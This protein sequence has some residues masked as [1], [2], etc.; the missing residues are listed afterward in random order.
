MLVL[1]KRLLSAPVFKDDAEET[2]V[3]TLVNGLLLIVLGGATLFPIAGVMAGMTE[4]APVISLLS[5]SM[6]LVAMGLKLLLHRGYVRLT[7]TLL[8]SAVWISFTIPI[9]MFDG[10]R[11]VTVTGYF[12]AIA[13]V[14]LVLGG[15]TLL[16]FCGLSS[17]AIAGAYFAETGGIITTSLGTPPSLVD[18]VT[19]LIALNATA[20]LSGITVGRMKAEFE[21]AQRSAEALRQSH[22][23]LTTL[24][25]ATTVINSD[26]SRNAVLQ[27]VAREMVQA[28]GSQGCSL[29]LWDR[30]RDRVETLIDYGTWSDGTEP[31]GTAYNLHDYPATRH[32]LE[33]RQPAIIH[34]DDATADEA[35]L[36][37]MREQG[38]GT[39]LMLPW[40][41][42]DQVMGL[43]ELSD[44]AE[45][46]E[47]APEEIRLAENLAAQAAVA[48][49]NARLY[50][51][52]RRE[53]TERKR[54]EG[55]LRRRAEEL[56]ALQATVLDITARH[57]LPSLLQT[58]VERAAV[59]L[60]ASG[61]GMYLCDPVKGEVRCVVSYN[62]PTDYTGTV[63][64]YSEGAAGTVAQTGEPLIIDDYRVW[65]GRAAV[66][67]E[68]Q[69]FTAVLSVPMIWQA[70]VRGVI[71]VLRQTDGEAFTQADLELLTQFANHA[72]IAVENARLYEEAT[73]HARQQETL[74]EAALALTTT[75]DWDQV[76]ERL[77]A[78]LQQVV[79]YD[80][81][82][83]QLLR[84]ERGNSLEIVGGRGFP[85]LDKVIGLTFD[86]SQED[87]PNREVIRTRAPFIVDDAPA[88]YEE[89]HREPHASA[90]I[91]S[92]LGVPM[93]V[94]DQLIGM[95]T[96]D[97]TEPGFYDQGHARLAETFAAQAAIA[98]ENTHLYE[99]ARQEIAERRRA[100]EE[101]EQSLSLLQAT[102]ESTA[103]GILVVDKE[104][105]IASFNR[106]FVDL[107]GIPDVILDSQSDD[108][109]IAF[110]LD[111]LKNPDSF[112]AKVRELYSQPDAESFDILEFK[113]GRV[114]ERYSQAQRIGKESVG[115]VWSFRDVTERVQ[116]EEA[117]RESEERFRQI[118]ENSREVFWMRDLH[119]LEL[120]YITPAYE[121]VWGHPVEDAY[122]NPASWMES[123]HP[124]DREQVAAAFEQQM[125]GKPTENEYRIVWPDGSIRWIRDQT[126][127][128]QNEA[129]KA[130]RTVGV[131]E[132][133][134]ERRQA[135]EQILRQNVILGAV[136]RVLE[137][138]LRCET[139]EEVAHTFLSAAEALTGSRFGFVGEVNQDGRFDTVALSD[140]GWDACRMPRSDAAAMIQDREIRSYWG[141]AIADGRS[142]IVNDPA[143]HPD[144]VGVPEGHPPITSFLG[145]PLREAGRTIGMIALA[146]KEGDYDPGDQR[147]IEALSAVF[148]EAL[149]RKRAE[150]ALEAERAS[151]AR[152]VAERTA[153]LSTA[154]VELTGALRARDEFL[155][156]MSHELRTPLNAILGLSEALLEEV[157][158]PLGEKQLR[159]LSTIERSG[160]RLLRLINDVLDMAKLSAGKLELA[161]GPISVETV[162]KESLQSVR[163]AAQEKRLRVTST[164]DGAVQII[165]ADRRRFRQILDKLLGNAVKFTAEGGTIGLEVVGDA[166]Q[167]LAHFTV[168]DTGIGISQEDVGRLFQTFVQLDSRL[169]RQYE[170][171]G[172]GLALARQLTELHGGQISV[173]SEVGKGSRFTASLPW[174]AVEVEQHLVT[175]EQDVLTTD[176]RSL[177]TVL[178]AEDN[179]VNLHTMSE[180]LETKGYRVV[181][182]RDGIEAIERARKE[183][184]DVI[185]MDI[186]MPRMDGLEATQRLR[187]DPKLGD[188]PIIALTAL[189]MPGDR[190]RCLEAGVNEYLSKPVSFKHL[191]EVI[192]AQLGAGAEA[193]P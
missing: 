184:P 16:L 40:V 66:Y 113:D 107:W 130:Y 160:R 103:D 9:Y 48:V 1:I 72:A 138:A 180:Y 57:D 60:D 13:M 92:W 108:Q 30:E 86:P 117:M 132:D 52:A 128:V 112:L 149:M 140:P 93:L 166:Q 29:S 28:L 10:I 146:N 168:W 94:G 2:R 75:L 179:E 27:T 70:Q 106:R 49:E 33:T 67:E 122:T 97:R 78:Q 7:G 34:V 193:E 164:Y 154:N 61:G 126:L 22:R 163:E 181:A 102:L 157:Y 19:L 55:A 172:M 64:R 36:A 74:R 120:I 100:E 51:Q 111:Q 148:V 105:R 121:H 11:D 90:G 62:T 150:V 191:V 53:I 50:E 171:T 91:R 170:G 47:Y 177:I 116:A 25:E 186:Q 59:L 188:T 115:R 32:V 15:R 69:P 17:L 42:R 178:L 18:L 71:H 104:G 162:C 165:Q 45:R 26:F 101:L 192:E 182:A 185:L 77:L 31:P 125:Q 147:A 56:A 39:L 151:L 174:Q 81:A 43:V 175:S 156:A 176:H 135:E 161:I 131:I 6:I 145:V 158:G 137:E 139:D 152:R 8:S 118:A 3:A 167:G 65:N 12:A 153:E 46:R 143:R 63:L 187:A 89:F 169:S 127:P 68:Q 98:M 119:S 87:N 35:E 109:A 5:V 142:L 123:V 110:V 14:S 99:Q 20:L 159:S 24:Y 95:L 129:G 37:V 124:E 134:T 73:Q 54:A 38:V 155:A 44:D 79:P 114:F 173:Q 83:V 58:I 88:V 41:A 141:K 190:E 85:N 4:S 23:E 84:A 189:V 82:S 96:L 136:N 76:I 183:R 144:R 80:T 21:R 133:F